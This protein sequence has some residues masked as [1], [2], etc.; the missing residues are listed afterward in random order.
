MDNMAHQ[1][2]LLQNRP[3]PSL[4][5]L[6]NPRDIEFQSAEVVIPNWVRDSG[7]IPISFRDGM[8][9]EQELDK[10]QMNP[11]IWG[12]NLPAMQASLTHGYEGKIDLIYIDQPFW[13][14]EQ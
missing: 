10:Q 6:P 7:Q 9:G 5:P 8:F 3:A 11:P 12:D 14:Q 2:A 13:P 1:G 4:A